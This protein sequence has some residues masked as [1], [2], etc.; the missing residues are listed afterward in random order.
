V[1]VT[2]GANVTGRNFAD[3]PTSI[4]VPLTLPPS[5]AFLKQGNANADFVEAL[6]R[7]ILKRDAEPSGLASWTDKLNSGALT[8]LQIAQGIRQSDE[9]FIQEVTDFYFTILSR[10]PDPTGLN[11]WVL[12]LKHGVLNEEQVAFSFLDSDEYLGKGD[13]YFVDHMYLSVL[14][15][16]FDP[17]GESNW[18]AGLGDDASGNSV[19][20]ATLT[21]EQ[22]ITN[23]LHSPESLKRLVQGYYQVFLGRLADP[24]G[25]NDWLLALRQGGSFL[26]IGQQFLSSDEFYNKAGAQG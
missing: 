21:H 17:S 6:Y 24:Q 1:T 4:A 2:S 16:S 10:T 8:R 9:H 26:T 22:V 13:K 19:Q 23:F 7:A 18:F 3:V 11:D 20:H 25:L 14:G 15:R 12:K 5:S